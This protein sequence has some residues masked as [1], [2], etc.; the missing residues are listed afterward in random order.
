MLFQG[1]VFDGELIKRKHR[2][3]WLGFDAVMVSGIPVWALPLSERLDAARRATRQYT[4]HPKDRFVVC[5]KPFFRKIEDYIAYLSAVDHAVDG[6]IITPEQ[7]PVVLGRHMALYK[8]KDNDKH[9]VDFAFGAPNVLKVFDPKKQCNVPVATLS[10]PP[11]NLPE[12]SIVEAKVDGCGWALVTVRHDK[13]TANDV[14]TFN[15]TL[16]NIKEKLSL[17]DVKTMWKV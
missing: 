5:F 12:D 1:T 16:L 7:T 14:L 15:K 4:E 13:T 6:T 3:T 11:A 10:N 17:E 2:W 9:T 8:L